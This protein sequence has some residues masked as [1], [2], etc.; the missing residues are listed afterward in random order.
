MTASID[1]YDFSHAVLDFYSFFW[2]EFCDWYLEIVKPR[3][4][5]GDEDAAANLLHVL[6]RV[7]AL[8]HPV[9]PFVTEEIWAYLPDREGLLIQREF[10]EPNGGLIDEEAASAVEAGIGTV[11][12]I[13]RWRD[14]VGVPAGAVLDARIAADEP[15]FVAR[16]A[17][18]APTDGAGEPVATI[19]RVEILASDE[20]DRRPGRGSGSAPSA[21]GF[22]ARSSASSASSATRASSPRRRP[23][24][25]RP[26]GR[27]SPTTAPSS[28][29]WDRRP[30]L[31]A[32]NRGRPGSAR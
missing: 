27:S 1:G 29:S 10:P 21:S 5:D 11:G 30:G 2:S 28:S 13:R 19:E 32:P 31:D 9:M 15:E 6:E 12:L 24:S 18:L 14:L 25:S 20:V 7:L 23:R 4:Y 26:S 16:L 8:M 17:R 3:L 22:R